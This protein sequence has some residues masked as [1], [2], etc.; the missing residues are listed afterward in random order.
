MNQ[1][2]MKQKIIAYIKTAWQ[3]HQSGN[4]PITEGVGL[5]MRDLEEEILTGYGLPHLAFQYSEMLQ[6]EGFSKK[7]LKKRAAELMERLVQAA[8][9]FL[10][11]P[12]EKDDTVLQQSKEKLQDGVEVL[13]MIGISTAHYN[14]FLYHDFYFRNL[15]NEQALLQHLKKAEV[16][17]KQVETRIP[18]TYQTLQNGNHTKRLMQAGIP[19]LKEYQQY[20]KYLSTN[21]KWDIGFKKNENKSKALPNDTVELSQFF[22]TYLGAKNEDMAVMEILAPI[23]NNFARLRI[24][25]TAEMIIEILRHARYYSLAVPAL[26][27]LNPR[28]LHNGEMHVRLKEA[29]NKNIEIENVLIGLERDKDEQGDIPYYSIRYLKPITAISEGL[30]PG[31]VDEF[32]F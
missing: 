11:A 18:F 15:L 13:P 16:L 31:Q 23:N 8:T 1:H 30:E 20:L 14:L 10:L 9:D 4:G 5:Q 6:F 17:D 25:C 3:W 32:P 21:H 28:Y 27:V 12:I 24:W 19:Y 2:L 29:N 22:V 7:N 26:Y